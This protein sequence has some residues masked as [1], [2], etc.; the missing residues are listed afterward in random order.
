[1]GES[2]TENHRDSDMEKAKLLEDTLQQFG[3]T[4]RLTGIAMVP[5]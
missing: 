3:I 5:R 1:M 4:T 2:V